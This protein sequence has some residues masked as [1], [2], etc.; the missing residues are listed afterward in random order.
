MRYKIIIFTILVLLN[1]S[2]IGQ[3]IELI[4]NIDF[5]ENAIY[6]IGKGSKSKSKLIAENFNISN[7]NITHIG[8]GFF[9]N[10]KL[11]IYHVIY[12]DKQKTA[13]RVST[14]NEFMD[15]SDAY[16]IGVWKY[17]A[18]KHIID[19]LIEKCKTF[20]YKHIAFDYFF[21]LSND[22]NLYCSEFCY[23]VLRSIDEVTFKF[24]PTKRKLNKFYSNVLERDSI[25]YYPVDFFQKNK[26]FRLIFEK[27][28]TK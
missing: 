9:R 27:R 7:K 16:Y 5:N 4:Q 11:T 14:L 3:N 19:T 21:T 17:K 23:N 22:N 15:S 28:I 20:E 2:N 18:T 24:T 1:L 13:L 6:L 26:K 12:G 8:I 25:I 10:N